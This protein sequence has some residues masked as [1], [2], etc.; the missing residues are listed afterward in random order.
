[1][2]FSCGIEMELHDPEYFTIAIQICDSQSN[3]ITGLDLYI[4]LTELSYNSNIPD[5]IINN[6]ESSFYFQLSNTQDYFWIKVY[7]RDEDKYLTD[8]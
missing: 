8:A 6:S 7:F 5:S 1:M 3:S 2:F 4:F